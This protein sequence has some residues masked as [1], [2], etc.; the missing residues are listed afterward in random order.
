[1]TPNG[2]RQVLLASAFLMTLENS[3]RSCRGQAYV[4]GE[5]A[6]KHTLPLPQFPHLSHG[7]KR[8]SYTKG[9]FRGQK[10]CYPGALAPAETQGGSDYEVMGPQAG[11]GISVSARAVCWAPSKLPSNPFILELDCK[12]SQLELCV[13]PDQSWPQLWS[14]WSLTQTLG[15]SFS[16]SM[17]SGPSS[18]ADLGEIL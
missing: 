4:C 9:C 3:S 12:R 1:M 5:R 7:Q 8:R 15:G 16:P 13:S 6:N 18:R 2:K 17:K 14:P 11:P 10:R